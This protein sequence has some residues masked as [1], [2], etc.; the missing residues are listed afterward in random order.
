MLTIDTFIGILVL[1][2]TCFSIG[3]VFGKNAKRM[4][5]NPWKSSDHLIKTV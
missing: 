1:C 2:G 3:Y 4:I 5:A